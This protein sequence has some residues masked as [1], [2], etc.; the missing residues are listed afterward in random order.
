MK[1]KRAESIGVPP[2]FFI[3]FLISITQ[4]YTCS[5]QFSPQICGANGDFSPHYFKAMGCLKDYVCGFIF[6][7]Y[8][9]TVILFP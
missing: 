3:S 6:R 1:Q 8:W 2:D 7:Y 4:W 5:I 9:S